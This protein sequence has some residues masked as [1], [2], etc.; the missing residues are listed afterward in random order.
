MRRDE[1]DPVD[2]P[3]PENAPDPVDAPDAPDPVDAP[4]APDP[5]D[6]PFPL[7]PHCDRPVTRYTSTGPHTHVASPCG[8]RLTLAE[9]QGMR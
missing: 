9:V 1:P 7:C 4:D 5:A 8:C 2:A 6:A 3:D